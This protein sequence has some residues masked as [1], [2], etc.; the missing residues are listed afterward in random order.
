MHRHRQMSVI[1]EDNLYRIPHFG[2][3]Q[4]PE[5]SKV[6]PLLRANF[7][8]LKCGICIFAVDRLVIDPMIDSG[9]PIRFLPTPDEEFLPGFSHR[10]CN[11]S[12]LHL[13]R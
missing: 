13:R 7:E 11:P 1:S 3:N 8:S 9:E 2:T 5:D 10:E 4:R 6:R 12:P